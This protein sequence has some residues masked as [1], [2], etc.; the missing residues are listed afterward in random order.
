MVSK[1]IALLGAT[2]SIG[3]S[4]LRVVQE[5]R[6][7][8]SICLMTAHRDWQKLLALAS[9]FDC[10]TLCLTGITESSLQAQIRREA[11]DRK[12]YF[13][14]QEL[15]RLLRSEVYDLALNAIT[16]SAGLKSSFAILESNRTLALANKESLVMAGHLLAPLAKRK[17][18]PIL[19]VD[20]EHSAIFQAIGSHPT[21]QIR[22]L[23]ITASGGSFRDLPLEDF[24]GITV[25]QALKH[26]NWDM[27]AKVTLD[28]A[29]MF[30]K[31]LE[32][33]EAHWLFDLPYKQIEAVIHPQSIIHSLVEFIDGSLLAQMSSPDMS[34]PI[35]YALSYPERMPSSLVATDLLSMGALSF[36]EIE[37][38]RFPLYYLGRE[39]ALEG[40]ILP[41][42]LNAANEA[43]LQLFLERKISFPQIHDL[44]RKTVESY[45][46]V[47]EPN[48]EEIVDCNARV[49]R[50]VLSGQAAE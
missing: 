35:L 39:V 11:G 47:P 21:T 3:A 29:T 30:N 48:L 40:G 20:S 12:V 23:H 43:A 6:E 41:T 37:P 4:T 7:H 31:A 34:L 10:H 17:G 46:N 25:E 27:G 45:A 13:G 15:L 8:F 19:P 38:E 49:F 36:R 44:V 50:S 9:E 28:S 42:V 5:Q 22:K 18:L 1:S 32:V 24:A 16:G 2:G 26:P 33:M 14:E